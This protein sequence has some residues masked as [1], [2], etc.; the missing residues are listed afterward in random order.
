MFQVASRLD[1]D[2]G[3]GHSFFC[4]SIGRNWEQVKLRARKIG[5][6]ERIL[7]TPV[8]WKVFSEMR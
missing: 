1:V 8:M 4:V 3:F 5:S 7:S 6:L 2:F